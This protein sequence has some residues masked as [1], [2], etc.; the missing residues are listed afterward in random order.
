M[1]GREDGWY[2][3]RRVR[4]EF[5]AHMYEGSGVNTSYQRGLWVLLALLTQEAVYRMLYRICSREEVG[6]FRDVWFGLASDVESTPTTVE[7][8]QRHDILPS[9]WQ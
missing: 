5:S 7:M 8:L 4:L 2:K 3:P 9:P 6:M 1:Y